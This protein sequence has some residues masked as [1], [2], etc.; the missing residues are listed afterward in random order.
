MTWQHA[1]AAQKAS[2]T[3]GCIP[4]SVGSRLREGVLPLY[5]ALVRPHPASCFQ[6]WSPQHKK[7]M[8]LLERVQRRPQR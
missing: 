6:L 4:S 3:L 8:E 5:S 7:D 1:L 2:R